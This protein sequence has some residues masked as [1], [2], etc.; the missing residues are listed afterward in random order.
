MQNIQALFVAWISLLWDI[1]PCSSTFEAR[2]IVV[3]ASKN[4]SI[5]FNER[6][7]NNKFN[8]WHQRMPFEITFRK[9]LVAN[10]I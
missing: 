5:S 7:K 8:I 10:L 2:K 3:G 4:G 6:L 9:Y 1:I